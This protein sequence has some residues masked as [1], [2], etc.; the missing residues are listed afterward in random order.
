MTIIYR[1]GFLLLGHGS[2][3]LSWL[4][5]FFLGRRGDKDWRRKTTILATILRCRRS[6]LQLRPGALRACQSPRP[7]L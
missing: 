3:V 2:Q 1:R 5:L 6:L 4:L 7:G